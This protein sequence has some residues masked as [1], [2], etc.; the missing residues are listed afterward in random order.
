MGCV[1]NMLDV[2]NSLAR[3]KTPP[4][5]FDPD[6]GCCRHPRKYIKAVSEFDTP[7]LYT[8]CTNSSILIRNSTSVL[9]FER[10]AAKKIK[11]TSF[12]NSDYR[13]RLC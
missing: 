8:D 9:E 10:R 6:P 13:S 5:M 12:D 11:V 7:Y 4:E 1:Y 2:S 3:D